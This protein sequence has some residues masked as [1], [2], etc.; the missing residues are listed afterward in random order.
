LYSA[1][2]LINGSGEGARLVVEKGSPSIL[3]TFFELANEKTII[4]RATASFQPDIGFESLLISRQHCCIERQGNTYVI[5]ELGSKHGTLLNGSL[6]APF[7]HFVLA[8]S[9]AIDLADGVIRLRFLVFSD[10]DSTMDFG[11]SP[12]AA[13]KDGDATSSFVVDVSKRVL[14]IHAR[15]IPLAAKEWRLLELLHRHRNELVPYEKICAE[16]WSERSLTESA[17]PDVGMDEMNVLLHRL[18]RKL[19]AYGKCLVTRRGQG[20]IL[21]E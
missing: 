13:G 6:L 1:T 17:M 3:G 10:L 5:T 15:E 2:E 11:D 18:R 12:L 4:G 8:D 7:R 21:E 9:D 14:Y 16:V 20:C 19:G